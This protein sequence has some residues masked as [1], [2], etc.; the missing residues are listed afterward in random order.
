MHI[1]GRKITM[2]LALAALLAPL[3]GGAQT[4]YKCVVDGKTV[5]QS[6]ACPKAGKLVKLEPGPTAAEVE[7][8]TRRGEREKDRAGAAMAVA[9]ARQASA[10]SA[11]AE[12]P[13]SGP[14]ADCAA[15]NRAYAEA[16]GRRNAYVRSRAVNATDGLAE[17]TLDDVETAERNVK[18]AGCKL[19]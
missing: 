13:R 18:R 15:L 10:A 17:R 3:H 12:R 1:A 9:A 4:I 14:G 5:Y 2:A 7:E 19:E 16:W 11:A 6:E 8:A